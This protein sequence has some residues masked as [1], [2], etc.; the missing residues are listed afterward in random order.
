[1]TRLLGPGVGLMNRLRYPQKFLL[2][3]CLFAVPLVLLFY[4]WL[5]EIGQRLAFADKERAGLQY[6]VALRLLLEPLQRSHALSVL[7]PADRPADARNFEIERSRI[8]TAVEAVDRGDGRYGPAL[9][10]ADLWPPLRAR[11]TDAAVPPAPLV[12]ETLQLI[13]HVGDSS[14]L[15]LDPELDSYYMMDAV[16]IRLPALSDQLRAIGVALIEGHASGASDPVLRGELIA[17]RTR[18]A[19]ERAAL[20]RGHAV[21]FRVNPDLRSAL[22]ARSVSSFWTADSLL[23]IAHDMPRVS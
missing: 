8:A 17:A 5:A 15:I 11:L 20:D 13:A 23:R 9:G 6:V 19:A 2:I 22:E 16:V 1:M 12:G 18:V 7:D 4:L 21:A 10:T 14:N 3:S